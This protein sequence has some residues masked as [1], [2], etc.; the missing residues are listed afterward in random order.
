MVDWVAAGKVSA[1]VNQGGCGSCWAFAATAAVESLYAIK[2]G[3][4]PPHLSPQ[5]LVDCSTSDSGCNGGGLTTPL[6]Y[7]QAAGGVCLTTSYPYTGSQGGCRASSCGSK[8][9]AIT[10]YTSVAQ[11][12]MAALETA[13][14]GQPVM[15]AVQAAGSAWQLYRSGVMTTQCGTALDHAV[16]AVG[17]G[18]DAGTGEPYWRIKNSWGSGWGEAG[19]LRLTKRQVNGNAG[20]C[21]VLMTPVYP[22]M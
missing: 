7:I 22:R 4:P 21:G 13:L 16:L 10:G 11:N 6:R 19:Y 2:T 17:Y 5:Q 9:G 3:N 18:V 14:Q 20:Q 1:V 12:N 8:V 15:V